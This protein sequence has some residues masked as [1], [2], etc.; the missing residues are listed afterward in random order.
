MGTHPIFESD[1]DCQ[2][3]EWRLTKVSVTS[4][5][6][7]K[8]KNRT[9]RFLTGSDSRLITKSS[10]TLRDV[11]GAEPRLACKLHGPYSGLPISKSVLPFYLF[12]AILYDF[13]IR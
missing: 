10:T 4:S 11:T 6:W 7:L 1:F 13:L 9:D 12:A 2:Q 5:F 8:S 3:T